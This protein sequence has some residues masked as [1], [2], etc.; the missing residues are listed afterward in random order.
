MSAYDNSDKDD[1]MLGVCIN[2]FTRKNEADQYHIF[3]LI[4]SNITK[5]K[6]IKI[7]VDNIEKSNTTA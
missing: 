1:N 7:T 3:K 4:R 5:N 2:Y 6:F